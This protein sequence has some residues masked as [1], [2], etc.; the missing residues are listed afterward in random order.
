METQILEL[1]WNSNSRVSRFSRPQNK[2]M[3][4]SSARTRYR[5]MNWKSAFTLISASLTFTQLAR[6]ILRGTALMAAHGE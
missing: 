5:A 4:S 6:L 3:S 1:R 2:R